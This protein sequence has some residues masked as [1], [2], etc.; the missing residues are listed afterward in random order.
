MIKEKDILTKSLKRKSFKKYQNQIINLLRVG[1]QTHYNKYFEENKNNCR[2]IWI[3]IN[4][5]VWPKNQKPLNSPV[6]LIDEGK[7]IANPKN[8]VGHF[9][10]FFTETGTNIQNTISHT[11]KYHKDCLLN[12]N[13][14]IFFITLTTDEEISNIIFDLNIRK[15]TGPNTITTKVMKQTKIVISAPLAKLISRSFQNGV[16]PNI[17]KIAKIPFFKSESTVVCNNY[18]PISLCSQ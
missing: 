12:P 8:I 14:E 17:L 1:K 15:S 2:A 13:K 5:I 9:Y 3:S 4:E 18:Q 11:K 6:S 7:T 10:K 16:F